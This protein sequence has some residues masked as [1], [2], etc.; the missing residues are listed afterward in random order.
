[1]TLLGLTADGKKIVQKT[2]LA[3]ASA[4]AVTVTFYE[5]GRIDYVISAQCSPTAGIILPQQVGTL[6]VAPGISNQVGLT[7]SANAAGA[8]LTVTAVGE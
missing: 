8:T 5:V 3:A 1:M 7:L 6:D 4:V 2:Q